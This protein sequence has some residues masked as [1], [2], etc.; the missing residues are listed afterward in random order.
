M[1]ERGGFRSLFEDHAKIWVCCSAQNPRMNLHS[2]QSA[3]TL[4]GCRSNVR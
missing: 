2:M 1:A 3:Q 4:G